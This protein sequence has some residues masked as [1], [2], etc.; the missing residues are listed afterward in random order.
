[1]KIDKDACHNVHRTLPDL[2]SAR[3]WYKLPF[4]KFYS[5]NIQKV[6]KQNYFN[7]EAATFLHN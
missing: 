7:S 5:H 6:Y 1:M 3:T 2:F 4:P